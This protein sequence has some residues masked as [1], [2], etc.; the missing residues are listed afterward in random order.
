MF[1]C[2]LS[3]LSWFP[4][5]SPQRALVRLRPLRAPRPRRPAHP[6]SPESVPVLGP[7]APDEI[8]GYV[9]ELT[10][11][12]PVYLDRAEVEIV[13][14]SS[15]G[16]KV[17]TNVSGF[18][19]LGGLQAAGF[20]LIVR[21]AAYS[22]KRFRVSQLGVDVSSETVMAPAPTIVSDVLEGDVCW[23]TRTISAMFTPAVA[24]FLR[25]TSAR[26]NSTFRAVYEDGAPVNSF[27]YN[28]VDVS[29]RAGAKYELRVTGSCDHNPSSNVRLTFLRPR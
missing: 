2:A 12:G 4:A 16:R 18:F 17:L 28:N 29:M 14:G 1:P 22:T 13:G 23:P 19:R 15:D 21:A 3:S 11:N 24:G 10:V 9:Q 20:D 27:L 8:V 6:R 5:C 7:A 26:Y 25:I